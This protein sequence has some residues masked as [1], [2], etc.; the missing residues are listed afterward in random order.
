M[1]FCIDGRLKKAFILSFFSCHALHEQTRALQN[2]IFADFFMLYREQS[3]FKAFSM[4]CLYYNVSLLTFVEKCPV[5]NHAFW[6]IKVFKQ[7]ARAHRRNKVLTM[8]SW[9]MSNSLERAFNYMFFRR[10]LSYFEST[11]A[12]SILLLGVW[13]DTALVSMRSNI[14]ACDN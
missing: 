13:H 3:N 6:E 11:A 4:S 5:K 2:S 12:P 10:Q 8:S 9:I 14:I 1:S 7:I